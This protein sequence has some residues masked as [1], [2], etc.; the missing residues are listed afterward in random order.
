VAGWLFRGATVAVLAIAA[1]LAWQTSGS[2]SIFRDRTNDEFFARV[3]ADRR[4]LTVSAGSFQL[5]QLYT[6]RC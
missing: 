1:L 5:L 2:R 6:R 4:G 3:A